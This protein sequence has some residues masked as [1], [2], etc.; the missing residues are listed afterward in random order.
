MDVREAISEV[1]QAGA[2]VVPKIKL[3]NVSVSS[4]VPLVVLAF[5]L[6][7]RVEKNFLE[8]I[9]GFDLTQELHNLS[10]HYVIIHF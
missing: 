3:K 5:N 1:V 6:I 8:Y 4:T 2:T 9:P 10:I 7:T